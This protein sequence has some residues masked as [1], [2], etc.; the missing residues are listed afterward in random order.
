MGNLYVKA[1][2]LMLE[3]FDQRGVLKEVV[4][5]LRRS[6]QSAPEEFVGHRSGLLHWTLYCV[7]AMCDCDDDDEG[8]EHR[9]RLQE[10]LG[11]QGVCEMVCSVLKRRA[12]L[13]PRT[14]SKALG[15]ASNMASR[16][17]ANRDRL[18]KAGFCELLLKVGRQGG[19]A[20]ADCVHHL[21][22]WC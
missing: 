22:V 11:K 6:L 16:C 3:E 14:V 7:M 20:G 8:V 12:D 2:V 15:A 19:R 1:S 21:S 4:G 13:E 17:K 18:G 10:E 9:V 5:A